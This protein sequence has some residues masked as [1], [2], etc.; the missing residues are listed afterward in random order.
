MR[1]TLSLVSTFHPKNKGLNKTDIIGL[2][3]LVPL[4]FR[5]EHVLYG[6][7]P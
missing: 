4:D 3:T 7:L 2:V 6:G 1:L 5:F